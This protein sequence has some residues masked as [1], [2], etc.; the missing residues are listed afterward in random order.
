MR[1]VFLGTPEAAVPSLRALIDAGHE[2]EL[3]VTREDKRR[4]RGPELSA[5]PIKVAALELDLRVSHSLDDVAT[6]GVERGVVVAYGRLIPAALLDDVPMLNAHFSL[7]PRWRGAAPVERAILAGDEETGV[8]IM[9]LE[10]TLDSGPVHL[11]RRLA[12]DDKTASEATNELAALGATAL[13]EVL[14]SPELLSHP[15][16]QRGEP[17]YAAKLTKDSYRLSPATS[18]VMALRTVRLGGAYFFTDGGRV[19]VLRARASDEVVKEGAL[20]RRGNDVVLGT[21]DGAFA[22]GDVR[23]NGAST[24]SASAWWRG[25]FRDD[26]DLR[27]T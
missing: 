21:R 12:L 18:A 22:L 7:L 4:A 11:E 20:A 23:P 24:M 27:W 2:V 3:V 5:S 15:M 9:S 8:S 10:A 14:G 1:L 13:V 17:T 19:T 25:R 6:S 26:E 16:A